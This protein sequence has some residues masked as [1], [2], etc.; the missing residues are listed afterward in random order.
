MPPGV[1]SN[2]LDIY[3]PVHRCN[4]IMHVFFLLTKRRTRN[5]SGSGRKLWLPPRWHNWTTHTVLRRLNC[6]THN[7]AH[8]GHA[9]CL[10]VSQRDNCRTHGPIRILSL[11]IRVCCYF[12]CRIQL[13]CL[14]E[15]YLTFLTV[16]IST[17]LALKSNRVRWVFKQS[18]KNVSET[19]D[20]NLKCFLSCHSTEMGRGW[21]FGECGQPYLFIH[22]TTRWT[23][24]GLKAC[25]GV[26]RYQAIA[27]ISTMVGRPMVGGHVGGD[28]ELLIAV[29]GHF[30]LNDGMAICFDNTMQYFSKSVI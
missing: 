26:C 22:Q 25:S 19:S 27:F 5:D 2:C 28:D 16:E 11:L 21:F 20:K 9:V 7:D 15:I 18:P 30:Q 17:T 23:R 14:W 1:H 24:T 12:R 3:T 4:E 13:A 10:N 29:M 6:Q 8:A